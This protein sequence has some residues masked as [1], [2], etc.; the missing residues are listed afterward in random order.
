MRDHC[1]LL[2]FPGLRFYTD[3]KYST[4]SRLS[5]SYLWRLAVMLRGEYL[6]CAQNHIPY[7]FL[8]NDPVEVR[9]LRM[10]AIKQAAS[11]K[12]ER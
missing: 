1:I 8:E 5:T 2:E 4:F 11:A 6:V 7:D 3:A 10:I 9:Q 12:D